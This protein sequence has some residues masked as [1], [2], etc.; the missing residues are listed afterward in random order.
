[1]NATSSGGA[2]NGIPGQFSDPN[3]AGKMTA[4]VAPNVHNS[5]SP[6]R[7]F[8]NGSNN[9]PNTNAFTGHKMKSALVAS[10]RTG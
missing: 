3:L 1:M 8:S 10:T 9:S 2:E 6:N 5:Y 7:V 4:A